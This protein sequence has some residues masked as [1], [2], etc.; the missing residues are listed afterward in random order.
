MNHV[1][2]VERW[3][4]IREVQ[5]LIP[6]SPFL[7]FA[8]V[9]AWMIQRPP[10]TYTRIPESPFLIFTFHWLSIFS[11][12]MLLELNMITGPQVDLVESTC[13][14]EIDCVSV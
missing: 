1:H 13:L 3:L 11:L 14:D 6:A 5:E 10:T 9:N 8:F 7:N 4:S 2:V 12:Y